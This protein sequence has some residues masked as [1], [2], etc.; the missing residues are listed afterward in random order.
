VIFELNFIKESSR[1]HTSFTH[2]VENSLIHKHERKIEMN[3][4]KKL[5]IGA[6]ALSLILVSATAV[7]ADTE[8]PETPCCGL[9]TPLHESLEA[10][11]IPAMA[12]ALKLSEQEVTDALNSGTTF[13]ALASAAGYDFTEMRDLLQSIHAQALEQAVAD[14]V[15]TPEQAEWL[16]NMQMGANG[17]GRMG[18]ADAPHFYS[19]GGSTM[20]RGGRW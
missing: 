18:N 12:D 3:T 6:L 20:G 1:L 7:F 11:M 4:K 16:S 2:I 10:Y 15:I 14:G 17:R 13:A 9:G 5:A 8:T 19:S